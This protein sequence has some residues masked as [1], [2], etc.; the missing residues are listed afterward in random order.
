MSLVVVLLTYFFPQPYYFIDGGLSDKSS[1]DAE[2]DYL[3]NILSILSNGH[4]MDFLHPGLPLTYLSALVIK[5]TGI[6]SI[7]SIILSSRTI[8]L[9]INLICIYLGSRL[10]LR[11]NL[12]SSLFLFTML[13]LFPAGFLLV[14]H[15]SP[16]SILFGL[17]VLIIAIGSLL[18]KNHSLI[19]LVILSFLIAVSISVKY[20]A[21]VLILPIL[22]SVLCIRDDEDLGLISPYKIILK[23]SFFT[24][25]WFSIIS[26]SIVPFIPF[27]MT[28]L[29][30]TASLAEVFLSSDK[31]LL[32]FILLLALFFIYSVSIFLHKSKISFGGIYKALNA[33]ILLFIFAISIY[34]Y[35]TVDIE[36]LGFSLRN[37]IPFLG[38]LV[39]FL[40]SN[41][42]KKY[43]NSSFFSY[44]LIVGLLFTSILT[45]KLFYNFSQAAEGERSDNN[46]TNFLN[47]YSDSYDYLVFYPIDKSGSKRLFALWSDHR[48]GDTQ[49]SFDNYKDFFVNDPLMD[50][51]RI[52]NSRYLFLESSRGKFGY[53]YFNYIINSNFFLESHKSIASNQMYS[54]TPKKLC[55]DIHADYA[56][57]KS[58]L[59]IFP[60]SLVSFL[61]DNEEVKYDYAKKHIS[62]LRRDLKSIC[63]IS[64]ELE[65][66]FY[67]NQQ[68][69]LLS[70]QGKK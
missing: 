32:L 26:L 34:N 27:V 17:S 42:M 70:L 18:E 66:V 60:S 55:T 6:S 62:N 24:V 11:Q 63:K 13:I 53:S 12:S 57:Q 9:F 21:V 10:V 48:Y 68:Y 47:D 14:D 30:S 59:I 4:T 39:L 43:Q 67:G 33:L 64:S 5:L 44:S 51:M 49:N 50:K 36:S 45:I 23:L 65:K 52:Y 31:I 1:Y 8:I 15:L 40:P 38:S 3:A 2:A 56:P 41:E 28:Q 16:N 20:T 22:I 58:S 46:F 29:T 19:R 35:L 61:K 69:Y 37:F 54:L 7:E 25:I